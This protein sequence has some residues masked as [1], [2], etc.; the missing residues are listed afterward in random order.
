VARP[1]A[2]AGVTLRVAPGARVRTTRPR[3][4]RLGRN[5]TSLKT[6]QRLSREVVDRGSTVRAGHALVVGMGGP[7]EGRAELTAAGDQPVR[8][9]AL[10]AFGRLLWDRRM[11]AGTHVLDVGADVRQFV[12]F[13]LG[14]PRAPRAE[15]APEPP[16][17][18]GVPREAPRDA[19][20]V[21]TVAPAQ[22]GRLTADRD[23]GP[24][25]ARGERDAAAGAQDVPSVAGFDADTVLVSTDDRTAVG[26]GCVAAVRRGR[27]M[28]ARPDRVTG[29]EFLAE[30]RQVEVTFLVPATP[31]VLVV[32]L[33]VPAPGA[34]P[35]EEDEAAD[36]VPA[37]DAAGDEVGQVAALADAVA[38]RSTLG[39][40]APYAVAG[41]DRVAL[42]FDVPTT[43]EAPGATTF[44]V[45]LDTRA[46]YRV[47]GVAVRA[48]QAEPSRD[49]LAASPRWDLVPNW[50]LHRDGST[51]VRLAIESGVPAPERAA[52]PTV[53]A[54]RT[55]REGR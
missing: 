52:A 54:E 14:A 55:I 3:A 1:P 5:A 37:A 29:A 44:R 16:P 21:A 34:A 36:G 51:W 45:T 12:L 7:H 47:R 41:T 22:L 26:P 4:V 53:P 19:A 9:V 30:A 28:D 23:S 49:A 20:R 42:L 25:V 31:S 10:G 13:A 18:R 50:E 17:P 43:R 40:P 15:P 24:I 2:L 32:E 38:W 6:L 27:A 35:D 8:V 46:G 11:N 39:L 48:G 33:G